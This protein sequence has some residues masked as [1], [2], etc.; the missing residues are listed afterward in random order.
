MQT[1]NE[2]KNQLKNGALPYV[3]VLFGDEHYMIRQYVKKII[4]ATV[5]ANP[6]FNITELSGNISIQKIY[7]AAETL[8]FFADMRCVTVCD[9]NHDKIP[10]S[11]FSELLGIIN[12]L[13]GSCRLVLYFETVEI[14]AK[15]PSARAKKLIKAVETA[16]GAVV[17]ISRRG[18]SE[19]IKALVAGASKRGV[20]MHPGTAR[21]LIETSGTDL[22]TL[23]GELEKI[24][25]YT[26]GG[27]VT[28]D[29]IDNIASRSV[30]A[31]VYNLSKLII[32]RDAGAAQKTLDELFFMRVQPIVILYTLAG[33]YTDMVRAK[34]G[35]A[36]GLS[37]AEI[38]KVF[39]YSANLSF[40]ITN[41]L[42]DA[43][44][45]SNAA[46][47]RSLKLILESDKRLKSTPADPK[48]EL[49][50]LITNLII[51]SKI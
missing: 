9:Y 42:R 47:T 27:A 24:C 23:V 35:A 15:K 28:D 5:N 10:E 7:D 11:D 3:I 44:K 20:Q 16:G 6:D 36:Q 39:G 13:D 37:S 29:I 49:Q 34:L 51:A 18:E 38:A 40:R 25:A 43:K 1:E 17:N 46:L 26:R 45:F 21:H 19:L 14:N 22:Q 31:S 8:P 41:A 50:A 30:D 48:I 12:R 33:V 2:L 32:M 4:A